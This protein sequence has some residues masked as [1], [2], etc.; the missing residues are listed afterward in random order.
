MT[1]ESLQSRD[2]IFVEG[3]GFLPF[4]KNMTK[5]IGKYIR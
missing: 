3:Y 5:N 1:R 4:A 2:R